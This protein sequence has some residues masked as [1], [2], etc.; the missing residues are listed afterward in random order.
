MVILMASVDRRKSEKKKKFWLGNGCIEKRRLHENCK[1][2]TTSM[3]TTVQLWRVVDKLARSIVRE[4]WRASHK[5]GYPTQFSQN[6]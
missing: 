1:K 5:T 6:F 3:Q 2:L 4:K